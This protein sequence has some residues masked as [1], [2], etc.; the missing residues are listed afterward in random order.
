MAPPRKA[1]PLPKGPPKEKRQLVRWDQDLDILLL[2]TVQSACNLHGVKI[3]W[4]KVAE[5]MGKKF[6]EGAIVQH[7]SKLRLRREAEGKAVPPPLR[8]SMVSASSRKGLKAAMTAVAKKGT[9][10]RKARYHDDSSEESPAKPADED[11]DYVGGWKEKKSKRAK[12]SGTR[13]KGR[14]E[15][16]QMQARHDSQTSEG[17]LMCEGAPFLDFSGGNAENEPDS[18]GPGSDAETSSVSSAEPPVGFESD[19]DSEF[20]GESEQRKSRIVR[21]LIPRSS[22]KPPEYSYQ[23]PHPRVTMPPPRLTP[24]PGPSTPTPSVG[25]EPS[26]MTNDPALMYSTPPS[27]RM[28]HPMAS[29][30]GMMGPNQPQYAGFMGPAYEDRPSPQYVDP[31]MLSHDLYPTSEGWTGP[32]QMFNRPVTTLEQPLQSIPVP[33]WGSEVSST[34]PKKEA[35]RTEEE[36][37]SWAIN[38]DGEN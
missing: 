29:M 37:F 28:G 14:R 33:R 12:K 6:T 11:P 30:H 16:V 35:G 2:L 18:D 7:L 8:R 26:F 4:D 27:W 36:D 10:K 3:P 1:A 17:D 31:G 25:R 15:S 20:H 9:R 23:S 22:Q 19:S 13:S 34:E 5:Q 38:E 21:L 24:A 32:G